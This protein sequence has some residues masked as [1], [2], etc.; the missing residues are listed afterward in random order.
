[1][2]RNKFPTLGRTT[3][4]H[5]SHLPP[6]SRPIPLAA[7]REDAI[8]RISTT[9]GGNSGEEGGKEELIIRKK[10]SEK[11]SEV[12]GDKKSPCDGGK[13]DLKEKDAGIGGDVTEMNVAF[14]KII[15]Y[16]HYVITLQLD[17][18]IGL[19]FVEVFG[20]FSLCEQKSSI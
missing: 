19:S 3:P 15:F 11:E 10:F 9:S 2:V 16:K 5:R 13:C 4:L 17:I 12:T 14:R 7:P 8:K 18:L 20:F 6:V 1:M